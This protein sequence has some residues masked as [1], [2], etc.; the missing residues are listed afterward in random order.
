M[1]MIK[2][3]GGK[4]INRIVTEK[5]K[6]EILNSNLPIVKINRNKAVELENIGTGAFSPLEGFMNEKDF[7]SV[8]KR[9][10]L[11]NDLA[12]TIPIVLDVKEN[13]SF[14][15]G[16]SIVLEFGNIPA[17][18]M[19]VESI[20]KPDK[21]EWANQVFGTDDMNHPG[22]KKVFESG[23][24]LIGGKIKLLNRIKHKF[25][26]YYLTPIETRIL[27]KEKGWKTIVGFQTRNAPHIG[28]EYV[29][30]TALTFVDGL[31]INPVIGKKKQG[32]FRDE[33]IIDAY[34][35]LMEKYY[36][37]DNAVLSILPF[38]M[39]YAGPREAILHAIIRKNYGCTHFIIGRDHAGVGNYY[40][41]YDAQKIFEKYPDIGITPLFFRSFFY[42]KKCG[43]V[44]NEKIC[45]HPEEYHINFS[46][47]KMRKILIEGK[48]PNALLMRPEVVDTILK[49]KNPF[50]GEKNG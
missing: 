5:E 17:A 4:L 23:N 48:H 18:L 12:W 24:W 41:P 45:P 27:F 15:V 21:K 26:K 43:G 49:Y 38:E 13:P 33:V 14:K 8:I 44:V 47:T 16:D 1:K 3:H 29:Q 10:R 42:C 2:P 46:G 31:F 9:G 40:G 11:S 25:E 37:K 7:N 32:D 35:T 6:K 20:F 19:E 50:V 39:R 22:V 30:K 34:K 36:L 28:H